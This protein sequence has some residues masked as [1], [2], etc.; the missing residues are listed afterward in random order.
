MNFDDFL[1]WQGPT[2][3]LAANDES[4]E[5]ADP[6]AADD[7]SLPAY[8]ELHC[9]SNFSFQR[10]A[11]HPEEL[12]A[13]AAYLGYTALAITDECSLA[14]VV[15]ALAEGVKHSAVSLIV[16]S[17]FRLTPEREADTLGMVHLVALAQHREGYGNLSEMITLG[18]MRGPKRSYRLH[19]RDFSAPASEQAHL[20][21]LPGCLMILVPDAD[22]SHERTLAQTRWAAQTFGEGRV[23]LALERRHRAD[24]EAHL[25]RL[26]A[27]SAE[28]G[29]P[30]VATG[31]VLMHVRSRKPLQDTLTAIGLGK[32]VQACGLALAA[33]AEQHLRTRLRLAWL[34]P[35][36][37]L[38]ETVAIASRCHFDLRSLRYEYPEELVP[39]GH[40]PVTY[41]RQEVEAGAKQRY[42]NGLPQK[43]RDLIEDELT[44]IGDLEYE[45]YFLTVY[46][47]VR[48][49][50]SQNILCQGRGS[51]ANS[52]VCYCLGITAVNPDEVQLLFGRFLSRE[53]KEPPDI[54]VDFEHQRREE[55]IQYIYRKYGTDR[56]A[57][58]ATVISYRM[59]SAVRDTGR[60]LG[61]DLSIVE[62]IAQS[63]QWWDG[64]ENLLARM[65]AQGLSPDA[66]TTQLWADLVARLIGFP[67]HLSQHVG[68]FV[69]SRDRLSR[70]VPIAP[71][72]MEDRYVIQWDKDDIETLKLLKVDVLA[73][74]MLSALRR[75]LDL[76]GEWRGAPMELA[77][78][79]RDDPATYGM[80][81]RAD[82]IGVFQ[83]ESRA[84]MSMLPR[85]KPDK[86]Y[87]LVIEVAIVR[88][89]PIQG[90]MVHPYLRRKQGKEEVIYPREEIKAALER[91]L[92]V[93]IFQ[94]QV[95]QIA[96]IAADFTPGDADQLRRSMAAWKRKGGL[97]KFQT[98]IIS[99]MLKN[100]YPQAFA[101]AICRQIEGFGEY[102]FP[103]SHAA[104]FALLAY[105]SAWLK[106]HAPEMFLC[107]LLNSLP[108][109]F[110]SA[111]QLVQD[112]R[113]HRVEVRAIDVCVS[114]VESRPEARTGRYGN[115]RRPAVRLG[116]SLV[117]GL[118]D[119]GA[120]AI[121]RARRQRPFTDIDDLTARA[122]LSRRDL[123]ALAAADALSAL[124]GGRRQ[125]RWTVAA[126]QPPTPLLGATALRDAVPGSR[127]EQVSLPPMPEG[128][129]IVADY[130]ST[131][132]TL[133]RHPLLLL[134]E[135]LTRMRVMTAKELQSEGVNGHRV[136]T[137]GIV[138]GRQRPGT[139]N[140]T[141]FVSLEDETGVINVIVWPDLV[142]SQRKAL[143]AASLLGVEGV[144]QREA[145]VTHLVAHRLVDLSPM[146]GELA[147][148]SRNFH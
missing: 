107:G 20:R 12:I 141:V 4:A 1:P 70:L 118:S 15:R 92:G 18:R 40:T 121:E 111:S 134:R 80:I 130:A 14:G 128:Q 77:D 115:A 85:L 27:I 99:G 123:D 97:E 82:T 83:I 25:A 24:D 10:G 109:G 140:G 84:Q 78:I 136:R 119:E 21:G 33:N 57:L 17:E 38:A 42:P 112:A 9:L 93:P 139:A 41:L 49:A 143:L 75:T 144:W 22:A 46:D 145:R 19:T 51:A 29:V 48:Y 94:E 71:A 131:G 6:R 8:A 98:R 103:E 47:I 89:G 86:F 120:R 64:R 129:D 37:T 102:G 66:P 45:P 72:A 87:D 117:R 34:Y 55:V 44:L 105:A 50:R 60:A 96:M 113:R 126:W 122:T 32:P 3:G 108:M 58:A 59:R 73:L 30:L 53:R 137:V 88:P 132:L 76:L 69:I 116:L 101:E 81:R 146:L 100:G 28:C 74:G 110:Y 23:W 52:A 36:D 43:V 56:A 147:V 13:R 79:P 2:E 35:S 142:E 133:R 67:R 39:A 91:T 127:D 148:S 68:G 104:S 5:P 7:G 135:K 62:Q 95:M 65:A 125:A 31:H 106:C 138:T 90:G 16:G 54:D 11:S 61:I 63:Q 26:R 114:D 124:L